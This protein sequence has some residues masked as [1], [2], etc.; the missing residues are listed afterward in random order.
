MRLHI[1]L[2]YSG[3]VLVLNSI[4]MLISAVVSLL[5]GDNSFI[6]LL[7][8]ALILLLFGIFPLIYVPSVSEITNNEGLLIVISSWLISCLAG[9]L[10]YL[11]WGGEFTFAN[12]WFESVS[13][14]TT[15]G[16]SI[17]TDIEAVPKGLLFW[18]STTHLLGGMGIIL[19]AM[20]IM[21]FMGAGTKVLYQTEM[22]PLA[23]ENFQL[24][25]KRT[26]QILISVYAS[27][28]LLETIAL[29][30]CGMS[31][32]DALTHSFATI[33][34]GGFSPKN[35]SVAYYNSTAIEI[36]IMVFMVISGMNFALLF[37][38]IF[39]KFDKFWNSSVIRYYLGALLVGIILVTINIHGDEYPTWS[40]A[41]RYA[42]FQ[43]LSVGTSTGFATTDSSIWPAFSQILIIFFSLQCASAGSTSGGIKVDRIVILWK[44]F[45]REIKL[46]QHP[47][48]VIP[49]LF[50]KQPIEEDAVGKSTQYITLYIAVVFVSTLLLVT[51]GMGSIEAFSGTVAAMGNVGPGLGSVGS[52]GNFGQIPDAGKW[53]L[54]VVM[55]LG[56]LE[57]YALIRFFMP[58]HW[59]MYSAF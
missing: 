48:A 47:Q 37:S 13:G 33:A 39:G 17:L 57:I 40:G 28:T 32:F 5:Y 12:A 59:K 29:L 3:F 44:A 8:S 16:S 26:V 23:R 22:S 19:F 43:L 7:Y 9:T 30:I 18:R 55:L 1:L 10:P 27:L 20:S 35:T 50:S 52:A 31:L 14:F 34:T 45:M 4:G 58:N 15:T 54:S 51:I 53:I 36:V 41:L 2:R 49:V 56:R 11:L 42:S 21:P 38:S 6:P 46:L 24:R 25:A